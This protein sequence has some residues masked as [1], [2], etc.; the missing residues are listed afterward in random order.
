MKNIILFFMFGI[1]SGGAAAEWTILA[2]DTVRTEGVDAG[3]GF[4]SFIDKKTITKNG[5]RSTMWSLADYESP[6]GV[7]GK[8][9]LS[10]KSLEEYDCQ[11]KEFRTLAFY[12]FSR[13]QAE[14][15]VVHSEEAPG[16][17]QP[18]VK[19]SVTEK[20]WNAACGK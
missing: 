7:G 16:K 3:R 9:Q 5:D 1:F 13:H 15:D 2:S 17:M 8:K 18:I 14:G 4:K 20:A 19:G 11:N 6:I 12:W 10:S